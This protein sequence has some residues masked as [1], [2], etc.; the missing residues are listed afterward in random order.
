MNESHMEIHI[1]NSEAAQR[2]NHSL[3]LTKDNIP[4]AQAN[5]ALYTRYRTCA[6]Q[7]LL[8]KVLGVTERNNW[9][10]RVP[11]PTTS[12]YKDNPRILE[13]CNVLNFGVKF[14][15]INKTFLP[16]STSTSK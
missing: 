16:V 6:T 15:F 13:D 12:Y 7:L 10:Q 8:V 2:I 11:C 14:S 4:I 3:S 9:A 5:H 1:P